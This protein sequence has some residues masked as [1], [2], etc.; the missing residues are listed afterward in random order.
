MVDVGIAISRT[1]N[2]LVSAVL[3]GGNGQTIDLAHGIAE[4]ANW[5]RQVGARQSSI[6]ENIEIN[7]NLPA[8][9]KQ[10]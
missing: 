9:W 5:A 2:L 6:F 3:E 4:M 7:E 1:G 8:G 10:K